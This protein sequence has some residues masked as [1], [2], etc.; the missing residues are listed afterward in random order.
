VS[1][2]KVKMLSPKLAMIS[3]Y[4]FPAGSF[5]HAHWC[6]ACNQLHEFA[7][8][9]PFRNGARWT[10]N[11]NP[12]APTFSPS[13]N[14]KINTPDMGVSYQPD[15]DSSVCHYFLQGGRIQYLGDCTHAMAGQTVDLP[16]IPANRFLTWEKVV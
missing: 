8:D 7:V 2:F 16:D 12:I 13:M 3:G 10:Y 1:D 9:Q 4:H 6:P 5:A 14:I 11:G 15:I